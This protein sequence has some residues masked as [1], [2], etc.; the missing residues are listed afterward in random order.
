[1]LRCPS[2]TARKW[3]QKWKRLKGRQCL[4]KFA[5][6]IFIADIIYDRTSCYAV[7]CT[8]YPLINLLRGLQTLRSYMAEQSET[9]CHMCTKN[10][11]PILRRA[12]MGG[13][14]PNFKSYLHVQ[15]MSI[16]DEGIRGAGASGKSRKS[17]ALASCINCMDKKQHESFP[18]KGK[19]TIMMGFV[20]HN[21]EIKQ[22]KCCV[23]PIGIVHFGAFSMAEMTVRLKCNL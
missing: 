1:M 21:H 22:S 3:P 7:L 10:G 2:V 17:T 23:L 15:Y 19:R 8:E 5:T 12:E 6:I 13:P 20:V 4:G 14:L 18:R 16:F 11:T 9:F